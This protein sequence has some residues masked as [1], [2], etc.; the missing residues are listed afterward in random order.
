MRNRTLSQRKRTTLRNRT[1]SYIPGWCITVTP[2][3]TRVVY[4]CH[5]SHNPGVIGTTLTYPG[6]IGTSLTYPG[7]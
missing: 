7:V 5:T 6:V 2:L 1:L 3:I 4:N